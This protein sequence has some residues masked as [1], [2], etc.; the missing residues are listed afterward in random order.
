VLSRTLGSG[1][2]P[3]QCLVA[4]VCYR[5]LLAYSYNPKLRSPCFLCTGMGGTRSG[6]PASVPTAPQPM[7]QGGSSSSSKSMEESSAD[8]V[9]P[10]SGIPPIPQ[11]LLKTIKQ[12]KFVD[13]LD[14]LLKASRK[15]EFSKA[16]ESKDKAKKRRHNITSPLD[17]MAAFSSYMAV[18]MHLKP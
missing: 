17:W 8:L 3:T 1:A 6:A 9:L 15:A 16:R 2:A 12:G 5:V 14:L 7:Q 11:H 13:L 18:E 10:A 4:K